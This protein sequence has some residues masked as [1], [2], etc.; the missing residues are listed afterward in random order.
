MSNTRVKRLW[1]R[2]FCAYSDP[3]R[4]DDFGASLPGGT[5]LIEGLDSLDDGTFKVYRPDGHGFEVSK[6][7]MQRKDCHPS[8]QYEYSFSPLPGWQPTTLEKALAFF[9]S[10]SGQTG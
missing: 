2:V 4:Q 5:H 1:E 6:L 3:A 8:N 7:R 9:R 10:Y